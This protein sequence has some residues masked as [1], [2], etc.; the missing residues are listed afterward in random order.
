ML[1]FVVNA[2]TGDII[3]RKRKGDLYVYFVGM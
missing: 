2:G 1:G 3:S